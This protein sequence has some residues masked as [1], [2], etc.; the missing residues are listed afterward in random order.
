MVEPRP[1]TIW[2][3]EAIEDVDQLWGH[4]ADIAGPATADKIVREIAKVVQ[5]IDDSFRGTRA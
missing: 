1:S 5:A 4:Y 2:S 3:P